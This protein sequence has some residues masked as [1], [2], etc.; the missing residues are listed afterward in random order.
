MQVSASSTP[1]PYLYKLLQPIVVDEGA[2]HLKD[3]VTISPQALARKVP[4]TL[5]SLVH[6]PERIT[7]V[8]SIAHNIVSWLT[9][10][11]GIVLGSLGAVAIPT[12]MLAH[13]HLQAQKSPPP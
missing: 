7:A 1:N 9:G 10:P 13:R 3:R 8:V 12:G 11:L 6:F 2:S 5:D 4:T